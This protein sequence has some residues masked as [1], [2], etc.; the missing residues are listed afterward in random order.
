M[1]CHVVEKVELLRIV[2]ASRHQ[3]TSEPDIESVDIDDLVRRATL[4]EFGALYLV[5]GPPCQPRS[6]LASGPR[7]LEDPRAAPTHAFIRIRDDSATRVIYRGGAS[8]H[9][10]LEEMASMSAS[11]RQE[12]SQ[13]LGA[14]PVFVNSADWGLVHSPPP[15]LGPGRTPIKVESGGRGSPPRAC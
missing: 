5:G 12:L 7:G 9:W 8:V 11:R 15:L 3:A 1:Q 2:P 10:L 6:Q 13:L 4:F 14:Q